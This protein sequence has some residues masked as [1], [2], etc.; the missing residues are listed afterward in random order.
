M[1][2]C[3]NQLLAASAKRAHVE[4]GF[5]GQFIFLLVLAS[6][7]LHSWHQFRLNQIQA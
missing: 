2:L 3:N 4:L 7:H 6:N 1:A 5:L